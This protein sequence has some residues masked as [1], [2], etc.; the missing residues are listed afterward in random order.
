[1][2][3]LLNPILRSLPVFPGRL[4]AATVRIHDLAEPEFIP[5]AVHERNRTPRHR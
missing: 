3:R 4:L 2:K 5:V 1:M